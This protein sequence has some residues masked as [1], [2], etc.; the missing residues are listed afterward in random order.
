MTATIL[1]WISFPSRKS[2]PVRCGPV[3]AMGQLLLAVTTSTLAATPTGFRSLALVERGDGDAEKTMD[4]GAIEKADLVIKF[5]MKH[6]VTGVLDAWSGD[7]GHSGS[8]FRPSGTFRCANCSR[9]P[10][11]CWHELATDNPAIEEIKV[12]RGM[13]RTLGRLWV[14]PGSTPGVGFLPSG[15]VIENP[16]GSWLTGHSWSS[17]GRH[18]KVCGSLGL[19][20]A[21]QPCLPPS[22]SSLPPTTHVGLP[23]SRINIFLWVCRCPDVGRLGAG[24]DTNKT[25]QT[26]RDAL[27]AVIW[28]RPARGGV[29]RGEAGFARH[30][31]R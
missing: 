9:R 31:T 5:G 25:N 19:R 15:V 28:T 8:K 24:R 4:H 10:N 26:P 17:L 12:E 6:R 27:Q 18:L 16:G 7:S 14:L 30:F 29:A 21:T 23:C 13:N 2:L 11:F 22:L 1:D 20:L 3:S